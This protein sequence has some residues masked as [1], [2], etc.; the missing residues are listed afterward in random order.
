MRVGSDPNLISTADLFCQY[1]LQLVV[2]DLSDLCFEHVNSRFEAL[3]EHY[4]ITD[5]RN[6]KIVVGWHKYALKYLFTKII[7]L[8]TCFHFINIYYIAYIV[9][10]WWILMFNIVNNTQINKYI[11]IYIQVKEFIKQLIKLRI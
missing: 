5:T 10:E 8:L 4:N 3:D 11:Y 2:T 1:K 6:D 9:L 7:Y